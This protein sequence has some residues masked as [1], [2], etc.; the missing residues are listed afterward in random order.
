MRSN[1]ERESGFIGGPNSGITLRG[2]V[3]L[4]PYLTLTQPPESGAPARLRPD[5]R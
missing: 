3:T 5:G 2:G 1:R 4:L